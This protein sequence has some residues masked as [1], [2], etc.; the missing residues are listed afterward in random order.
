MLRCAS[1]HERIV[2][3]IPAPT[4]EVIGA[5]LGRTGALSLHMALERLGFTPC[6]HLTNCFTHPER[7]ALWL[8]AA[9]RK[10]AGE[11][12]DWQPLLAEFTR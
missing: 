9:R 4:L 8:E 7:F 6:E 10:R 12:T 5:G 3:D 2:E 1:I 11:S